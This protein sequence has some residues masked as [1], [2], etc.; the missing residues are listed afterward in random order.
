MKIL[1]I[2][3]K[4]NLG[5]QLQIVFQDQEVF[6]WDRDDIDITDKEQIDI[7]I[8]K[9]KPDIIINAAAYNAVDKC[10]IDNAEF[11]LAKMLNGTA[12][13]YL[14]DAAIRNKS[15]FIHFST[16]HVFSGHN[17]ARQLEAK[18]NGGF[19]E[20]DETATLNRYSESKLLGEK[21]ILKRETKGLEYYIV[22]LSLLFGPKG[23]SPESKPSFFD[24]MLALSNK[25]EELTV[26]YD[27][28]SCFTYSPDLAQT[29]KKI[30]FD[31]MP[32]GIYHITNSGQASWY[33]GAR[34]Y[35]NLLN[36]DVRIKPVS[37]AIFH[38]PAKRPSFSALKNTKLEPLR[39]Y[40]DALKDYL[41]LK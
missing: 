7:K 29:V 6:A 39:D 4:G 21:E 10:E 35:F 17:P 33:D 16:D 32:F 40:K 34:E 23:E 41:K 36:S 28:V 5:G 15:L 11:K 8:D 1:I 30:V 27:E 9:L 18:L 14:A 22:R 12:V 31:K 2:G 3:A 20:D 19:A 26:V 25:Q 37:G 24:L 38:R 13:G